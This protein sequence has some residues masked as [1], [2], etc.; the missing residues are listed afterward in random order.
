MFWFF[1]SF[2]IW[3]FD[4][5]N[6]YF[7]NEIILCI[8]IVIIKVYEIILWKKKL[9]LFRCLWFYIFIFFR[10]FLLLMFIFGLGGLFVD[11]LGVEK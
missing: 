10:V 3:V 4:I 2:Y 11:Y 6:I 8:I 9:I 1:N 5:K 7:Y